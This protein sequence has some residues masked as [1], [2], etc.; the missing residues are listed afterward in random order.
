[1]IKNNQI[2]KKMKNKKKQKNK[3]KNWPIKK[4]N[5]KQERFFYFS[6]EPFTFMKN[7]RQFFNACFNS[8]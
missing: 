5:E 7:D 8:K 6:G 4:I 2:K 3:K 1:M